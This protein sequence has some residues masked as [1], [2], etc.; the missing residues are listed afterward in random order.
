MWLVAECVAC[1]WM[2]RSS[3]SSSLV[4]TLNLYGCCNVTHWMMWDRASCTDW[5]T[6]WLPWLASGCRGVLLH[7][8]LYF[9]EFLAGQAE[10]NTTIG[11]GTELKK[12]SWLLAWFA[13]QNIKWSELWLSCLSVHAYMCIIYYVFQ[14]KMF[15]WLA[16]SL[17]NLYSFISWLLL[18]TIL[19]DSYL[20][21]WL[22]TAELTHSPTQSLT[23]PVSLTFLLSLSVWFFADCPSVTLSD[24]CFTVFL[25]NRKWC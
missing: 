3:S 14:H 1:S 15:D 24:S 2:W 21:T 17:P 9:T 19:N 10:S 25:P 16:H 4:H 13:H 22:R 18:C 5:L 6:D 11:W 12:N 8:G 23:V 20:T 7:S